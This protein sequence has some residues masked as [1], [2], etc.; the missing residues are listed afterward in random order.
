VPSII[1]YL[2]NFP[3]KTKKQKAFEKWCK[4]YT[5][6]FKKEHLTIDGLNTIKELSKKVN[7]NN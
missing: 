4:I 6:M 3:L 5:M 7:D 2:S 1:K